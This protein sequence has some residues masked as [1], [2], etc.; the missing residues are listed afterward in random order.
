[1]AD[2]IVDGTNMDVNVISYTAPKA[3]ASGGKVINVHNKHFKESLKI[4]TPLIFTWGPKEGE[5]SKNGTKQPTGKWTM[6]L[7]FPTQEYSNSNAEAFLKTMKSVESKIREDALVNSLSWFGENYNSSDPIERKFGQ[8]IVDNC[9]VPMLKYPKKDK[10]STSKEVDESKPPTLTVKIPQ[11]SGVWK[12]EIYDEDG[13]PLYINGQVNTHLSPLEFLKPKSHVICL[14][15]C[16]GLWF[17]SGKVSIVWNLKQAI[18]QKPKPTIEGKCFLK[19]KQ[20]EKEIM[21]S[22]PPPEDDVCMDRDVATIVHDSDDEEHELPVPQVLVTPP[23]IAPQ[24]STKTED[25]TET[26]VEVKETEKQRKKITR[27]VVTK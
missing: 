4:S 13:T 11:W 2:T 22:L 1:M 9:F 8:K 3:H 16:G 12:P 6:S 19:P 14:L 15:E 10:N 27:K 25:V 17:V 23:V 7:Q 18:V 20:N 5:E 24:P 26:E 21:K